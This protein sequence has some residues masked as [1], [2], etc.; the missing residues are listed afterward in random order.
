MGV[1][2]FCAYRTPSGR[3]RQGLRGRFMGGWPACPM[4]G[5]R[6]RR[7]NGSGL[8]GS[9]APRRVVRGAALCHARRV[10]TFC[11]SRWA[12]MCRPRASHTRRA[13]VIDGSF[14][15]S[16]SAPRLRCAAGDGRVVFIC[17]CFLPA[18]RLRCAA[19]GGGRACH[20]LA[21]RLPIGPLFC[22]SGSAGKGVIRKQPFHGGWPGLRAGRLA[23]FTAYAGLFRA[24][25][26]PTKGVQRGMPGQP[27]PYAP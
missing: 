24:C 1:R 4:R 19:G 9:A 18:P 17:A 13:A 16:L 14:A 11:V 2:R 8:A 10:V 5:R 6:I 22:A 12:F 23:L 27:C 26:P 7:G 3:F 15:F 21:S 20:W 25:P